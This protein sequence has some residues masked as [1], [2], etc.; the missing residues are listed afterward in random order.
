M[1]SENEA[2]LAL[3]MLDPARNSVKL[4]LGDM[5][6]GLDMTG[7]PDWLIPNLAVFTGSVMYNSTETVSLVA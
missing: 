6:S 2:V 4:E 3:L 1:D 7:V 5:Y